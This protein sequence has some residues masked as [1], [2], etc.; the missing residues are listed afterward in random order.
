MHPASCV[1][2]LLLG[3]NTAIPLFPTQVE[4]D[5]KEHLSVNNYCFSL[6]QN[7]ATQICAW[8]QIKISPPG[9]HEKS[10]GE[11]N[12]ECKGSARAISTLLL[13]HP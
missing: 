8:S 5:L 13:S 6:S 11:R 7:L 9:Q 3:S 1:K 12:C 2:C 4:M 10:T